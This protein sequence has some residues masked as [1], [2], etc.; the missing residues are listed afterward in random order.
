MKRGKGQAS[1]WRKEDEVRK[2][3]NQE[4]GERWVCHS[5][6]VREPQILLR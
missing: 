4:W 2:A 3:S 1:V 5:R 6:M